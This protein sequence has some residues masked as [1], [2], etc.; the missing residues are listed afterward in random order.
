M[1][2]RISRRLPSRSPE[3]EYLRELLAESTNAI[4]SLRAPE[5]MV[6]NHPQNHP[7]IS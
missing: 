3:M 4:G 5:R 2:P 1:A 7:R 6:A